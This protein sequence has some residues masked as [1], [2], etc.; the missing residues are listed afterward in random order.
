MLLKIEFLSS[1]T[2]T[3]IAKKTS[4]STDESDSETEEKKSRKRLEETRSNEDRNLKSNKSERNNSDSD[5]HS[6]KKKLKRKD[7]LRVKS[8][9]LFDSDDSDIPMISDGDEELGAR[10]NSS[11]HKKAP[12]P[13]P[14]SQDQHKNSK[15]QKSDSFSSDVEEELS[16]LE[17]ISKHGKDVRKNVVVVNPLEMSDSDPSSAEKSVL[18][19]VNKPKKS[20]CKKKEDI[21][22]FSDDSDSDHA[23]ENSDDDEDDLKAIQ[24]VT[25]NEVECRPKNVEKEHKS[26][27]SM[28][29]AQSLSLFV[30]LVCDGVATN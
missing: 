22:D 26:N 3:N 13:K 4:Y 19:S 9:K 8:R 7:S 30:N 16:A 23:N 1:F 14:N 15:D 12:M 24:K 20:D 21:S 5:F 2:W 18:G 27:E 11:K 6:R 10:R 17:R 25:K 29:S 28:C